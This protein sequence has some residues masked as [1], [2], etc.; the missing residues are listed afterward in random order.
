MLIA[1]E[2][3]ENKNTVSIR[4]RHAGDLGSQSIDLLIPEI[5]KEIKTRRRA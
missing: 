3:E 5:E 4:R 2:K 1:G